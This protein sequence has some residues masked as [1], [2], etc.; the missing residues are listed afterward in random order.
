MPLYEFRCQGCGAVSEF[1]MKFSDSNPEICPKC[2]HQGLEKMLSKTSFQLK[3]GGWYVTDF[4]EGSSKPASD[5]TAKTTDSDTDRGPTKEA[6]ADTKAPE[7]TET[8]DTPKAAPTP[9]KSE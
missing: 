1:R 5:D 2:E 6:P 3:G 4:R 7:S 9:S 8:K